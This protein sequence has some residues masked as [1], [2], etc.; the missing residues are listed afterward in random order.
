MRQLQ[1]KDFPNIFWLRMPDPF[2]LDTLLDKTL[3]PEKR[4]MALWRTT[5]MPAVLQVCEKYNY[6][7]AMVVEDTVLLR[8]DVTYS[9]VAREIRRKEAPAGVWGYGKY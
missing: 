6:T 2:E 7:G 4:V 1:E 8:P 9:D 3:A 5:V